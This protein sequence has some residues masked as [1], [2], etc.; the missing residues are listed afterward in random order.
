MIL[1]AGGRNQAHQWMKHTVVPIRH[2]HWVP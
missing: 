1:H 2:E